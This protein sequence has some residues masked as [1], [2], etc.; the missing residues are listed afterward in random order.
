VNRSTDRGT[1]R[2]AEFT[3]LVKMTYSID[4]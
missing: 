2:P 1:G 3:L 4:F